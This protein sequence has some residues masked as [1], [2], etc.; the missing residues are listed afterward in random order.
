M[1]NGARATTIES[2][3]SASGQWLGVVRFA[4]L[5]R[6]TDWSSEKPF[7]LAAVCTT[8]CVIE[9]SAATT[10]AMSVIVPDPTLTSALVVRSRTASTALATV[11]SSAMT[12]SSCAFGAITT[13]STR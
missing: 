7:T 12:E 3:T 6:R 13:N 4:P 9:S 10:F 8:T 5:I 1:S 2:T 11:T